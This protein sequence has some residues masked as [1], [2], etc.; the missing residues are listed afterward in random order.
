MIKSPPPDSLLFST[1]SDG[2]DD[3][4]VPMDDAE[5]QWDQ[6]KC[7]GFEA[8]IDLIVSTANKQYIVYTMLLPWVVAVACELH[9]P[10]APLWIHPVMFLDIYYYY[11][12]G[13]AN[14]IG[15]DSEGSIQLRGLPLLLATCD[16]PSFLLA[17]NPYA[18]VHPKFQAQLEALEKE[19]NP[20][21]L[22]NTFDELEPE[23]LK[24]LE[25]H[26]LVAVGPLVPYAILD[27]RDLSNGSKNYIKWLNLKSKSLVIYVSFGSLLVL[28]KQQMEE[29][30]CGLL[31]FG[32]PFLWVIKAK[33]NGEEEKLS[34]GEESEQMGMIV[35]WCS[36]VE[37][38]DQGTNAKLIEDVWKT[39][40]R[41]TMNKD[42]IVEGDEIKRCLELVVGDGERREASKRNAK[43]WKE[44]AMKAANEVGSSSYNNLKAF[45]DG[46]DEVNVVV[47]R[48]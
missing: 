4:V 14:V 44:L 31:D 24:A 7:N 1:F 10:S 12:N 21:V 5:K 23:A 8:L 41:V 6:L 15:N 38:F 25:K 32:R 45:V 2:Y 33:E 18:F 39:G 29:I 42:G 16:L 46:I 19:S 35:P 26:N 34:C 37:W 11:Y 40:V 28:K 48:V 43:K 27:G 13:F 3:E 22:V 30:A 17:S 9:L 20:R 36:Q 47:K